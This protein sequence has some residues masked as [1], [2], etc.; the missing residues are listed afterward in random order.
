MCKNK[1]E[2]RGIIDYNNLPK[3]IKH[4]KECFNYDKFNGLKV[5]FYL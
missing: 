3:T 2:N 5:Y 1:S 4:G